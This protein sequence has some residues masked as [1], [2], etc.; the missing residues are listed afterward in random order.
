M[1]SSLNSHS[2]I[3]VGI[4]MHYIM[5][6]YTYVNLGR[7]PRYILVCYTVNI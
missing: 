4:I 2:I 7:N 6:M 1:S 5:H 3:K